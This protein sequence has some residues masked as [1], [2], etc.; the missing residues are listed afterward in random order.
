MKFRIGE[1]IA[2]EVMV[3]LGLGGIAYFLILTGR[4]F[5]DVKWLQYYIRPLPYRIFYLWSKGILGDVFFY[6]GYPSYVCSRLIIWAFRSSKQ[7]RDKLA[8]QDNLEQIKKD[9]VHQ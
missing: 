2:R 7:D 6:I 4:H 9:K 5:S 1:F 3:L 8:K